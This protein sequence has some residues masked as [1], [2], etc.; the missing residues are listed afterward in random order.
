MIARPVF[1]HVLVF[2]DALTRRRCLRDWQSSSFRPERWRDGDSS[3]AGAGAT[4]L[5]LVGLNNHEGRILNIIFQQA[6]VVLDGNNLNLAGTYS[7]SAN[8][9]VL[10]LRGA[11]GNWYEVSRSTL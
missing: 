6:L 4:G 7:A 1:V 5:A 9:G 3:G 11:F 2:A 8:G 10:V